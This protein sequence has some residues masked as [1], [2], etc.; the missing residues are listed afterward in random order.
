M[1]PRCHASASSSRCSLISSKRDVGFTGY[2]YL[3][4]K[5]CAKYFSFGPLCRQTPSDSMNSTG[6]RQIVQTGSSARSWVTRSTYSSFRF[7]WLVSVLIQTRCSRGISHLENHCYHHRLGTAPSPALRYPRG[8]RFFA[9]RLAS[10]RRIRSIHGSRKLGGSITPPPSLFS[11]PVPARRRSAQ[12]E[13][14]ESPE[15][16]RSFS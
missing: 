9:R 14:S 13:H 6:E 8:L 2:P 7:H 4:Q 3:S 5:V 10:K 16:F 12:P 11:L 15:L 1:H